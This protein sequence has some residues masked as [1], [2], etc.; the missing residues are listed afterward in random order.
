MEDKIFAFEV[1]DGAF[2]VNRWRLMPLLDTIECGCCYPLRINPIGCGQWCIK[3]TNGYLLSCVVRG[4]ITQ[5]LRCPCCSVFPTDAHPKIGT[6][7][8]VP[9]Y[10]A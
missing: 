6:V 7:R 5:K 9:S 8:R 2:M 1:K 4:R 10:P 3:Q